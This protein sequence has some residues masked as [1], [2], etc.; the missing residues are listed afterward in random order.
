MV[1]LNIFLTRRIVLNFL[2]VLVWYNNKLIKIQ[3]IIQKLHGKTWQISI[4][5][6]CQIWSSLSPKKSWPNTL[7][8]NILKNLNFCPNN[9]KYSLCIMPKMIILKQNFV[10]FPRIFPYL[11]FWHFFSISITYVKY[12]SIQ[13]FNFQF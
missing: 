9:L 4:L 7:A 1:F 8:I 5:Q 11:Q 6:C 13:F 10:I 12:N 2:V 3:K